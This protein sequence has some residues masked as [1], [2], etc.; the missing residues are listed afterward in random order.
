LPTSLPSVVWRRGLDRHPLDIHASDDVAWLETLVWPGQNTRLQGLRAA[1]DI[2]RREPPDIV[3][4]DLL[5]DLEP[6]MA[7]APWDAT[8]VVFHTAVLTYVAAANDREDFAARMR[9]ADAVWISN[10][11]PSVFP[12]LAGRLVSAGQGR[13]LLMQ[14][15]A[16]VAWCG[17]HGQSLEWIEPP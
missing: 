17:P 15:G 8:L 6:L 14:D 7:A 4:G 16:P 3:R 5:T 1:I 13:F 12:L 9:A 2:A 10:E 11:A